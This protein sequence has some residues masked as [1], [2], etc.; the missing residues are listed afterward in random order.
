MLTLDRRTCCAIMSF[1]SQGV[2]IIN[3][4]RVSL[5]LIRHGVLHCVVACRGH[6]KLS[7][8]SSRTY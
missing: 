8:G 6:H 7:Y 2:A 3:S 1:L 5:T 4:Y